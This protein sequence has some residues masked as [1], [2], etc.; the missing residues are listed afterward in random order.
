MAANSEQETH[1]SGPFKQHNKTHKTGRHR[2]KGQIETVGK[3]RVSVKT[4]SRKNKHEISKVNR[5][6][7]AVQRRQT[8]REE[9]LA[10]KRN[11]GGK[12]T[13]PHLVAVIGLHPDCDAKGLVEKLQSCDESAI[14][15]VNSNGII[16]DLCVPRFNKRVAFVTPPPDMTSI[17]DA[18]KTA[19]SLLC[20]VSPLECWDS[21]GDLC[22]TCLFSQGLPATTLVT[23]GLDKVPIKKRND[24]KKVLQKKIEKRFPDKKL[25]TL[26]TEQE[27]LLLLRHLTD[28]RLQPI[29]WRDTRPHL[30]ARA[31]T[32]EPQEEEGSIGTLK[33]SG[34]LRGS[35]LTVNGLIHLPGFGSFQMSQIDMTPDPCPMTSRVQKRKTK[36][37]ESMEADDESQ[38]EEG[39]IVLDTA[40]P[41]KQENLD[42]EAVPDPMEGEQTW[43]TEEELAEAEATLEE[44]NT[45]QTVKRVP[46]GT[47]E[48]QA[49]WIVDSDHEGQSSDED[50][51]EDENEDVEFHDARSQDDSDDERQAPSQADTDMDFD[52]VSVTEGNKA[53]YD[54]DFDEDQEKAMLEKYREERMQVMFPDEVDTPIDLA[55]RQRFARYRGLKSFRTSPWDPKEN[56]PQDYARIFQFENFNRTRKRVMAEERLGRAEPGCYITVHISNVNRS[57]MDDYNPKKLLVVFG[58]LPHEQKMSV[59]HFAIKRYHNFTE[60]V[61]S[62]ERLIFQVG[63]RQF[64]ACPIFSQ[65]SNG[66]KHKYVRFL[67]KD[68]AVVATVY[69]PITFPP[70]TVLVFKQNIDGTHS[71]VATGSML[72]ANPDRIVTKKISLSG[73][74]LKIINRQAVVRYMFFNREDIMWFK[75]V[76]LHTKWG[77]RGHI[78]EPL[79]THGHMKCIFDGKL[80]SQDTI[81][82][83]LYKRVYPKWTYDS[84]CQRALNVTSCTPMGDM[85]HDEDMDDY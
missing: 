26:D 18:A 25:Y 28:Q 21:W 83:N 16:T 8:K 9:T 6:H 3:G 42:S 76:E 49:A 63:F 14:Q 85:T 70:T 13:P 44:S 33:V 59:L 30:L 78:K 74:P 10:R 51:S 2:S 48:Y 40:D 65:H 80:K 15:S 17:L 56:L 23:Q 5:R 24:I 69:A 64:S 72:S 71:L 60:P 43:P 46:K 34:F 62:K 41:D 77:R 68:D 37:H 1:R 67:S 32:F 79:G 75:P 11:V 45:K 84:T 47:S 50:D 54:V 19:D 7:Q 22:L 66:D 36:G 81:F 31:V 38:M 20:L 35:P 29:K 53:N 52:S 27:G 55:A 82:L 57:F 12:D 73:H 39:A 4:Q 58:M 61:K